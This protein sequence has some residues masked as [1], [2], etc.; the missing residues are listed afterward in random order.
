M[1]HAGERNDSSIFWKCLP[2]GAENIPD[3]LF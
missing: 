2:E 1:Q 3:S